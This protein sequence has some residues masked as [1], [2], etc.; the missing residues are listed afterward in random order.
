MWST[1]KFEVAKRRNVKSTVFGFQQDAM[2]SSYC[3]KKNRVVNM[4]L[5]MHNQPQIDVRKRILCSLDA[6]VT[7]TTKVFIFYWF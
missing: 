4:H 1:I 3:P 5:T 6:A 2:I 7:S